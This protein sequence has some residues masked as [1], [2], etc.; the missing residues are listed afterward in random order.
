MALRI[1]TTAPLAASPQPA[2]LDV[3][4]PAV[5]AH[6]GASGH[7]PEHT[8]A[9][10]ELGYR[11][12]ADSVELD[13]IA[14]RDGALICRH[15]LELSRTTDIAARPEFAHL[16]RTAEIDG[17]AATGWFAS[18]FTLAELRELRARE[19]WQRKRRAS[20]AY[21]GRFGIP[22]LE[23]VL[24]LADRESERTGVRLRVHAELK[25]LEHHRSLGLDIPGLIAGRAAAAR[26]EVTW[27][28]FEA[29]GL[30]RLDVAGPILRLF[31]DLPDAADL[32]ATAEFAVG[33]AVRRKTIHPRG[34][35]GRTGPASDLVSRAGALGLGTF[36][37]T[38]R[39]ENKHLPADFRI[40]GSAHGHGDAAGEAAQL[41]AAGIDGLITDFPEI[42]AAARR[43]VVPAPALPAS[44]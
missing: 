26:P 42:A 2:A 34:V 18:D 24:E 30:R 19:R 5:I 21:D 4:L 14:T 29:G 3:D 37:W 22:T 44:G 39:A 6:R 33:I 1:A 41:F 25:A 7:R 28:G 8:L 15:D 11:L 17:A 31:D 27:F 9:A 40:G 36:V 13:L 23:D 43:R 10:Y 16:R 12:G 32:A 20:A 35:D 38:H